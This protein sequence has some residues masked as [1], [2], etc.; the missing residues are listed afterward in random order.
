MPRCFRP[1]SRFARVKIKPL[2]NIDEY[3]CPTVIEAFL[4]NLFHLYK[5]A[6]LRQNYGSS[7]QNF[8]VPVAEE[9]I[10]AYLHALDL[11]WY[12]QRSGGK[13]PISQR[14]SYCEPVKDALEAFRR[15]LIM[16]TI[17]VRFDGARPASAQLNTNANTNTAAQEPPQ[18][19]YK[20]MAKPSSRDIP[21]SL[22]E[23]AEDDYDSGAPTSD[24]DDD[25]E[26]DLEVKLVS[27]L[28]QEDP[29]SPLHQKEW[30]QVQRCLEG[31]EEQDLENMRHMLQERE[32]MESQSQILDEDELEQLLSDLVPEITQNLSCIQGEVSME[33]G[34]QEEVPLPLG[35]KFYEQELTP[36]EE[37]E[38]E[39]QLSTKALN[40]EEPRD[41]GLVLSPISEEEAVSAFKEFL[42]EASSSCVP[43]P[44]PLE[45]NGVNAFESTF[46]ESHQQRVLVFK[47]VLCETSSA[48]VTSVVH[49]TDGVDASESSSSSSETQS[50][51]P[52]TPPDPERFKVDGQV[53]TML[54]WTV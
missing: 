20:V 33:D 11:R 29:F 28:R 26:E 3:P 42:R 9:T 35:L 45:A 15:R 36:E 14:P 48:S 12:Q 50:A 49:Q 7:I 27:P 25:E 46:S 51:S 54:V 32:H 41:P 40:V 21:F 19:P 16:D 24:D 22:V 10:D 2:Q 37:E 43:T 1:G 5:Y 23:E 13:A 30:S 44:A 52:T 17:K 38:Q 18:P 34:E 8:T 47:D 53:S 6:A 31:E 4:H 39:I